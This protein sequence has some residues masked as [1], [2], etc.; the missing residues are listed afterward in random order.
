MTTIA[1]IN[2]FLDN[3]TN[4]KDY[5]NYED[6]C[7]LMGAK[8]LFE[9][10]NERRYADFILNYLK[11]LIESDGT[12]NNYE[13]GKHNIDG[14][15]AGKILFFAYDF[16]KDE[17]FKKAIEFLMKNLREQPRTKCGNFFHKGMYQNQVWLDG[18]YMAQP[19]YAEYE[20]RF[21]KKENYN[22]IVNQF[23][24]VRKYMFNS[25]KQLYYHGYDEARVQ[26]W[27]DAETGLSP[28]FWLRSMGWY[29]M[30]LIDVISVFSHEIYEQYDRL[31]SIFKEA[32]KGILQYQDEKTKLFYQVID[33]AD[34][35]GNYTETSGTAM[36]SYAIMKACSL[37]VLNSEKYAARGIEIF[38][39]LE[40]LK[41]ID[42]HLTGICSVA[43]L[44]PGD[45]RNGSVEYYISEPIVSDDSKGV[46]AFM[47]AY[48]QR[49]M[50]LRRLNISV[51][52]KTG[53]NYGCHKDC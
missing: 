12:I 1:Y 2:S 43:G 11:P 37:G 53:G 35:S 27:A 51:D 18:L 38:D 3:Y 28:N 19:F 7:V 39:N 15:N 24:N 14:F 50:L 23:E 42:G 13:V 52:E 41:L 33:R 17:I 49:E 40:R 6:G 36:I 31:C 44:G 21:N 25:E 22:D 29:V 9:A 26:K 10:T 47:M 45:T 48:A 5:W 8:Q 4:Y 34:F 30:A 46:G 32:I 20:T 16:T